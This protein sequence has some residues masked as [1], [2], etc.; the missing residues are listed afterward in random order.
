MKKS[1]MD[2]SESTDMM[3]EENQRFRKGDVEYRSMELRASLIDP[4][5]GQSVLKVLE[6]R[7]IVFNKATPLF[8]DDDGTTYYEQIHQD[9]LKGVDL[10]NVVLKYNHSEHVPPLASTKAG[11]LDLRVD[12]QGLNVTARMANTTQANDIHELVRSGHLDKMSFAF[13]VANDAYD[14]KTRTRTIFK[15]DKMYDVSVV[16]FPAYEETSV[17][18]RNYVQAQQELRRREQEQLEQTRLEQERQEQE[19]RA[20]EAEL[21]RQQQ[22]EERKKQEQEAYEKQLKRLRLK[23]LL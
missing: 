1:T 15:F 18:A 4:P 19:R 21:Q 22:V 3:L 10:S 23:T 6:G 16:D 12:N 20:Q 5:E 13:T 14:T 9:A 8:Q 7:A 17:S 11:T 2:E